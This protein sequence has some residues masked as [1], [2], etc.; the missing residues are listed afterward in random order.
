M[1]TQTLPIPSLFDRY[2]ADFESA[3]PGPG[4]SRSFPVAL[5]LVETPEHYEVVADLPGVSED[6][7]EVVFNDGVLELRG[8][9]AAP[10][11][12]EGAQQLRRERSAG[13]F[14]RRVAFR[15]DVEVDRIEA[16]FHAG[17]LRVTV[18]KIE[19]RQPRQI[20]VAVH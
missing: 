1:R 13:V 19:K 15:D 20:R 18:P 14:S 5:D 8:E 12:A 6:Q 9:R 17:V 7:V 4:Q 10:E 16:K 2:V 11:A 3:G